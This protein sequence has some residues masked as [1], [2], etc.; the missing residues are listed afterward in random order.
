[1]TYHLSIFNHDCRMATGKW[2]CHRARKISRASRWTERVSR[3]TTAWKCRLFRTWPGRIQGSRRISRRRWPTP[4]SFPTRT[5]IP[6]WTATATS[7]GEGKDS[8][9]GSDS[10]VEGCAAEVPRVRIDRG[11]SN[12]CATFRTIIRRESIRGGEERKIIKFWSIKES[13]NIIFEKVKNS[14]PLLT[15]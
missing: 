5:R 2:A 9:D 10:G 12:P 3:R 4:I 1:M 15:Y 13:H 8:K 7:P 14:C 6:R 11:K